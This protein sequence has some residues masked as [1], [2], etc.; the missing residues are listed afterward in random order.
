MDTF[1]FNKMAGAVLFVLLVIVGIGTIGDILV[2]P[3]SILEPAYRVEV[4]DAEEAGAVAAAPAAPEVVPI[5]VRL[6]QADI[7]TG[8]REAR[9]CAA[10][11]TFE[12][13]GANRVGPNLWD[14]VGHQTAHLDNFNYSASLAQLGATWSY[15]ALDEFLANPRA[16]LPGTSMAFA[17][18][19][20]HQDRADLIAYMRSLS[21]D[22]KPLPE[23]EQVSEEPAASDADTNADTDAETSN[24]A[25]TDDAANGQ[26]PA[27]NQ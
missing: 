2:N 7:E 13:G 15:E 18:I 22:P 6:A 12:Q 9:K 5:P 19:R 17:G 27:N 11:H 10:C 3:K 20:N 1:E 24:G 8:I 25:A 4:P 26:A 21:D 23:V 14:V 16:Y